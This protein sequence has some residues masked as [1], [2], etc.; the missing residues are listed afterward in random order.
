M[1]RIPVAP[2][3]ALLAVVM[4]FIGF[5][6]FGADESARWL[7]VAKV[8]QS[9]SDIYARLL[10]EYDKPP[11]YQEEYRMQDLDGVSSF[12][13]RIRGYAGKQITVTAPPEALYDV[14]F[15]YERIEQLGV[16]E[17][18]DRPPRGDLSTHYTIFV[19]AVQDFKHGDRTITFTDPHYWATTA[20]RQY[21]IH[22]DKKK[23]T[24]DLLQLQSTEIADPRFQQIVDEFRAF[25]P[26]EFR[27]HVRAAQR[28]IRTGR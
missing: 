21:E 26:P 12:A 4:A 14:S 18:T 7:Q 11:V 6:F 24:P 16:W 9:S 2:L 15:F 17:L 28:E 19:K 5:R 1:R 8:K 25:G 3:I 22:L 13:Y 10:V 23:P 20:G 27:A